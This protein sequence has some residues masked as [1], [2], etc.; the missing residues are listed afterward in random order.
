M[1]G[2]GVHP[3]RAAGLL[4]QAGSLAVVLGQLRR[5][6]EVAPRLGAQGE[7]DRRLAGPCQRLPCRRANLGDVGGVRV[8]RHRLQVVGG[9]HLGDVGGLARPGGLEVARGGQVARLA[10]LARQGPVGDRPQQRLEE[11]VG[12]PLRRARIVVAGEHLLGHQGIE[13]LGDLGLG[14]SGEG[15]HRRRR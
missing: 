2:V 1:H 7:R 11:A 13:V 8:G 10:A 9:Q 6:L 3:R 4:E 15:R 5:V 12:P 14:P